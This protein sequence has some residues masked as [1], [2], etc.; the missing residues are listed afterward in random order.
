MNSMLKG[1]AGVVRSQ[2]SCGAFLHAPVADKGASLRVARADVSQHG[3][4]FDVV[5]LLIYNLYVYRTHAA[6]SCL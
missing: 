4:S 6:K 3:G 5:I 2:Q 1:K